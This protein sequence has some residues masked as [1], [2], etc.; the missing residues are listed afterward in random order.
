MRWISNG[1]SPLYVWE[2]DSWYNQK[3]RAIYHQDRN[4]K[5]WFHAGQDKQEAIPF[6]KNV[7][8]M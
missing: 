2:G 5:E 7:K 4:K 8:L 3:T 1:D 6:K